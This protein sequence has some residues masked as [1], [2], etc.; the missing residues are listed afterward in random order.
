M[1]KLAALPVLLCLLPAMAYA[2]DSAPTPATSAFKM[3]LGLMVV[4]AV[5]A[6]LAWLVKRFSPGSRQQNS[7]ARVV[8][9]VSVGTRERVVVVEVAGRWIV[10]GVAPGHVSALA[11]LDPDEALLSQPASDTPAPPFAG[12]LKRASEK[13]NA[14]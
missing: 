12:W 4:L 9:G 11:N 6:V 13:F 1:K 14:K 5:M 2:A 8:G 10:V 3:T 7:V